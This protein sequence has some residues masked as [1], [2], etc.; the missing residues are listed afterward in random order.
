MNSKLKFYELEIL[1][2]CV[3]VYIEST[4]LNILNLE[5]TFE[6]PWRTF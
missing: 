6:C 3:F 5:N 4:M 1:A 2:E